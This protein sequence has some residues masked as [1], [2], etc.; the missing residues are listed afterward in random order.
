MHRAL[1]IDE[2]LGLVFDHCISPPECE[3]RRT[4]SQL[5]RCCKAWKDLALDRFWSRLDGVGPLTSLLPCSE[6]EDLD[7]SEIPPAFWDY[8]R[9]VKEISH[10]RFFEIPTLD[11]HAGI[12]PRLEAVTLSFH[13]CMVSDAWM[14]SPRLRRIAVNI[15][16]SYDAQTTMD[17]S[18]GVAM[19]LEQVRKTAPGLLSLRI[20]GRMTDSLNNAVASLTQLRALTIHANC[21]LTCETLA[22]V[23]SFPHLR[24]LKV[25]ASSIQQAD[26]ADALARLSTP[27][28]PAMEELAIRASGSVL[29]I[30]LEHLPAGIL[31]KLHAE[32]DRCSRGPGH[33]KGTFELL[34]QKTSQSLQELSIEDWTEFQDLEPSLRSQKSLEWY[35][36]SLLDPL[37]S[38]KELRRFALV[39]MLPPDLHD[40]D[41]GQLGKW[42]PLL[43][44]L[45]LGVYD[46]VLLPADWQM[47]MTPAALTA[48][49]KFLQRLESLA[50]PIL[51]IDL[52]VST[53]E[54]PAPG[55]VVPQ[56]KTL[57]VLAIGD[58]PDAAACAKSLVEAILAT[59]PSL[60]T[61]HCP[62]QEVSELLASTT[63]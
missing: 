18:N 2:I 33:L 20:R 36:L 56:Q 14:V 38:L 46:T 24:S 13:G 48:V 52:L 49:A 8:A 15:G 21:F 29:T 50:L 55:T 19:Y 26:F 51:P 44:H 16:Y 40:A 25:H 27:C 60:T 57:R 12:M 39:S 34:A 31:T 41:L 11:R 63:K 32:V 58:V 28:F 30:I 1:L 23:A 22:A 3:P 47:R 7:A 4:L 62:A 35:P 54:Q 53:G 17:R 42:W 43:E 10:H 37:A 6:E 9:R 59:F 45:N 61:L 5:A